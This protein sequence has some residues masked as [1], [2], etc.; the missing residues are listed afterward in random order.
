[1][2]SVDAGDKLASQQIKAGPARDA[3]WREEVKFEIDRLKTLLR[4]PILTDEEKA[5]A[6]S[7]IANYQEA[8]QLAPLPAADWLHQMHL[9]AD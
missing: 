5:I 9:L 4:D 7:Q 2:H 1:M 3:W 8:A 6:R